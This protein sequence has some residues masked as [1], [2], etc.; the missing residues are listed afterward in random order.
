MLENKVI[1]K[2]LQYIKNQFGKG[3]GNLR[4]S[5]SCHILKV[6]K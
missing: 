6:F 3:A 2:R 4:D 5:S 1:L